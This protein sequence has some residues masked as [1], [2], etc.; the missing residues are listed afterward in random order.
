[1]QSAAGASQ[2]ARADVTRQRA[3]VLFGPRCVGQ[4]DVGEGVGGDVGD[5]VEAVFRSGE[6]LDSA[7]ILANA[8][9]KG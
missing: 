5:A 4:E 7:E 2:L 1:M 3:I 6:R 9:H 8:R